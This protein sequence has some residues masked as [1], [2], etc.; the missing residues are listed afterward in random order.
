MEIKQQVVRLSFIVSNKVTK[1]RRRFCPERSQLSIYDYWAPNDE[2]KKRL[3]E[4]MRQYDDVSQENIDDQN[5]E[6]DPNEELLGVEPLLVPQRTILYGG[7]YH[8]KTCNFIT[9][10]RYRSYIRQSYFWAVQQGFDTFITDVATP[11]GL[12]ALETLRDLRS[13]GETFYLYTV[14]SKMFAQRKSYRLIPET[15]L[16]LAFLE[17]SCDYRYLH[18]YKKEML[19][20]VLSKIGAVC[21]PK[22]IRLMKQKDD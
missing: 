14:R 6:D 22:G 17:G 8:R 9:A 10:K 13:E 21:N 5:D 4:D 1:L 3:M 2:A 11:F 20:K 15:P 18:L 7:G 12:L 19:E 16:E